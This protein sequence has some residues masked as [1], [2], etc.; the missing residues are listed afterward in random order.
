[1]LQIRVAL[2]LYYLASQLAV[3]TSNWMW[4]WQVKRLTWLEWRHVLLVSAPILA[5]EEVMKF[6]TRLRASAVVRR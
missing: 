5:I 4:R 1:L 6:I 3:K 2:R